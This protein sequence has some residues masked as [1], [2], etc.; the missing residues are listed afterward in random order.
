MKVM[1]QVREFAAK[2]NGGVETFVAAEEADLPS[3][4][5]TKAGGGMTGMSERFRERGGRCTYPQLRKRG[6]TLLSTL[7][8]HG[9]WEQSGDEFVPALIRG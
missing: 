8:L 5:L 9:R 6:G 2:Q 7:F 3:E 1:Q 4:A